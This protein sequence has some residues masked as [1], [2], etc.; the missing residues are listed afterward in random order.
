MK[1]PILLLSIALAGFV[2]AGCEDE[3]SHRDRPYRHAAYYGGDYGDE[4]YYV[5]G[6]IQYYSSG[7]RYYYTRESRRIYVTDL[8]QGGR[9]LRGNLGD[10]RVVE[11]RDFRGYDARGD[12]RRD[13][14]SYQVESR[15]DVHRRS[16][17]VQQPDQIRVGAKTQRTPVAPVKKSDKVRD[18]HHQ[19]GEKPDKSDQ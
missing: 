16:I 19:K 10:D 13:Y 4:P 8:P 7:G 6:G 12:R 15:S 2:I 11:R 18:E 9:Y 3:R 17:Q 14:P 5:N 1:K